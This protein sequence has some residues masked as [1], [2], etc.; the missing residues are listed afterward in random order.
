MVDTTGDAAPTLRERQSRRVREE[1]R[2]AFVK[3]VVERRRGILGAHLNTKFVV[4]FVFMA[5]VPTTGLFIFSAF[6]VNR[7]I[8]TWFQ[9]KRTSAGRLRV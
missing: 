5:L 6:L 2:N 1:L 7:S 4:A 9:R 3:L 8:D